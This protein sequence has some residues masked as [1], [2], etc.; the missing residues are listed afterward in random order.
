MSRRL[1]CRFT[2]IEML[3]VIAII[4]ILAAMLSPSLMKARAAALAMSCVNNMKQVGVETQMYTNDYNGFYPYA[5][6]SEK[7][8][9]HNGWTEKQ[10]EILC[11]SARYNSPVWPLFN[12]PADFYTNRGNQEDCFNTGLTGFGINALAFTLEGGYANYWYTDDN[13]R[14]PAKVNSFRQPSRTIMYMDN[15]W[16]Y[17][18]LNSGDTGGGR[19]YFKTDAN[20]DYNNCSA[21]PRHDGRFNGLWTDGHTSTMTATTPEEIKIVWLGTPWLRSAMYNQVAWHRNP[22]SKNN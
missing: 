2:L 5:V 4:S 1:A 13:N 22:N 3:V 15:C 6:K 16:C 7:W 20:F 9:E 19:G 11:G 21:F 12:C 14:T 8:G 10:Y 17:N 18:K